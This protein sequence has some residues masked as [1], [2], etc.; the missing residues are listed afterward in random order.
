MASEVLSAIET[1]NIES[2]QDLEINLEPKDLPNI[3]N[4]LINQFKKNKHNDNNKFSVILKILTNY[5][6]NDFSIDFYKVLFSI[7][8]GYNFIHHYTD[9]ISYILNSNMTR[10]SMLTIIARYSRKSSFEKLIKYNLINVQ[11]GFIDKYYNY[12]CLNHDRKM[13]EYL[14]FLNTSNIKTNYIIAVLGKTFKGKKLFRQIKYLSKYFNFKKDINEIIEFD[15]SKVFK[16]IDIYTNE[17]FSFHSIK[18]IISFEFVNTNIDKIKSSFPFKCIGHLCSALL[19]THCYCKLSDIFDKLN[20]S[21]HICIVSLNEM[22]IINENIENCS[23]KLQFMKNMKLSDGFFISDLNQKYYKK[24]SS[25]KIN[26]FVTMFLM[27]SNF[28]DKR[29]YMCGMNSARNKTFV[30]LRQIIRKFRNIKIKKSVDYNS[31]ITNQIKNIHKLNLNKPVFKNLPIKFRENNVFT[32]TPEIEYYND[33]TDLHNFNLVTLY[34]GGQIMSDHYNLDIIYEY[35]DKYEIIDINSKKLFEERMNVSQD[36]KLNLTGLLNLTGFQDDNTKQQDES[37]K[38]YYYCN[39]V[40]SLIENTKLNLIIKSQYSNK[41]I[42]VNRN[43]V[44][45][46][47]NENK[48]LWKYTSDRKPISR[49]WE[50]CKA[51][52]QNI[53]EQKLYFVSCC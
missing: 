10:T 43:P 15:P 44:L 36:D 1:G 19:L 26:R 21:K 45:F 33:K 50:T 2:L 46:L 28:N 39:D 30:Y 49:A 20:Y 51:D 5:H 6:Y 42:I 13:L 7:N 8:D 32:K 47:E 34:N 52:E 53:I 27:S 4:N 40:K 31:S 12:I 48:Q 18:K 9:N 38:K 41:I 23:C 16:M 35:T 29:N 22:T 25:D 3:Y 37:K 17:Y 11:D 24:V 14:D